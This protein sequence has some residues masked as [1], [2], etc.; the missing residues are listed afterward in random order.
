MPI[1]ATGI[2][3]GLDVEALVSQLIL[4]DVQPS[5]NRL[6]TSEANYQAQLTAYGSLKSALSTFQS[7]AAG[8][9]ATTDTGSTLATAASVTLSIRSLT[10]AVATASF[11]S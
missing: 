8:S 9:A 1:T 4:A 7:V 10:S 5:E 2:G 11:C 6:N 3:S